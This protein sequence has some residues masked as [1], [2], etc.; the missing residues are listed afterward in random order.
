[1]KT[2]I[3]SDTFDATT[4]LLVHHC[5]SDNIFRLNFDDLKNTKIKISEKGILLFNGNC[6]I[7]SLEI[8]KVLWRKPFNAEFK[9]DKY[10]E[11]ELKYIFREIFNLFLRDGKAILVRPRAETGIGKIVALRV[12]DTYFNIPSWH[13]SFNN[14]LPQEGKVVKSLTSE[15]VSAGKILYTTAVSTEILDE[16]FPWFIQSQID[17]DFDVTTVYIDGNI[18][19]FQLLRNGF[20]DWRTQINKSN[21]EWKPYTLPESIDNSIRL[22][23]KELG[24]KFGRLDWLRKDDKFFFLEVNPNGQWAWLDIDNE[25][26]LMR[27]MVEYINPHTSLR[28]A[29]TN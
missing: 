22:F 11:A 15:L 6:E 12:A 8:K 16:S 3:F 23:M 9:Q 25:N 2:L 4:D 14:T 7:E 26:G 10:F 1:M 20:V 24:L 27:T 13:V 21:Q 28:G 17:A 29:L 18:F 19:S 5:G